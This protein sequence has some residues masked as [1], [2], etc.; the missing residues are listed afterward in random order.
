M[1]LLWVWGGIALY[2]FVFWY[3]VQDV[4][5]AAICT[6]FLVLIGVKYTFAYITAQASA[7]RSRTD[8]SPPEDF[9]PANRN[10]PP[11]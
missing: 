4:A 3:A 5:A 2:F 7:D 9:G 11:R 10:H 8:Q 6:F 1:R